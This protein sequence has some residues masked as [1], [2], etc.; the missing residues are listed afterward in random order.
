MIGRHNKYWQLAENR[1][2][3]RSQSAL[4]P[5]VSMWE[6]ADFEEKV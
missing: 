1:P 2:I 5:K 3:P 4:I 6:H